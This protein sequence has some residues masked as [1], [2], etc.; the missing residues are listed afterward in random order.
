[1]RLGIL[2]ASTESE[3]DAA[4]ATLVQLHA[5]ALV[6]A[7]ESFFFSRRDQFVVLAARHAVPPIYKWREFAAIGGLVSYVAGGRRR[8]KRVTCACEEAVF[9]RNPRNFSRPRHRSRVFPERG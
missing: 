5:G 9:P 3:I 6:V 1:M 7:A 4:F 8:G 2:K